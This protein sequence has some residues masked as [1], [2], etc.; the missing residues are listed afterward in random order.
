MCRQASQAS[1]P[2]QEG[3]EGFPEA[4]PLTTTNS[5]NNV[6]LTNSSGSNAFG[7]GNTG[8]SVDNTTKNFPNPSVPKFKEGDRVKAKHSTTYGIPE[9]QELTIQ[10]ITGNTAAVTYDGCRIPFGIN[11]PLSQLLPIVRGFKVGDRVIHTNSTKAAENWQGTVVKLRD[12]GRFDVE[13]DERPNNK[14]KR[15]IYS[16]KP[17]DLRLI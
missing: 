5:G 15:R 12:D 13:W 2:C 6:S 16:H 8:T 1:H 7:L 9:D 14:S 17:S 11:V 4:S 3:V 10:T